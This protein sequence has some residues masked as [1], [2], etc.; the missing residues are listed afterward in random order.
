MD[1]LFSRIFKENI[2]VKERLFYFSL[3]FCSFLS[4]LFAFLCTVFK[5]DYDT[6]IIGYLLTGVFTLFIVFEFFSQKT[7][8]LV[9]IFLIL[10]DFVFFPLFF[11]FSKKNSAEMLIYF[12]IGFL[13]ILIFLR[14]PQRIVYLS[15]LGSIDLFSIIYTFW[16]GPNA[17]SHYLGLGINDY[18]RLIFAVI[19]TSGYGVFILTFRRKYALIELKEHANE[20]LKVEQ[21]NYAKDMFMVNVSHEIRTPLNAIIGTTDYLLDSDVSPDIKEM[22]GSISNSSHA[23]LSIT[24]DLLD[25][26]RVNSELSLEIERYDIVE[27]LEDIIN[28]FNVRLLDSFVNFYVD[29]NPKLPT[30]IYG[31]KD[32]IRQVLVTLLSN[33][34]KNTKE[35]HISLKVDF[36]NINE[37]KIYLTF[38]VEDTGKRLDEEKIN[39]VF[40]PREFSDEDHEYV[41]EDDI[42]IN[43]LYCLKISGLLKGRLVPKERTGDAEGSSFLFEIEQDLDR[44]YRGIYCGTLYN[45]PGRILIYTDDNKDYFII[46]KLFDQMKI[47][48]VAAESDEDFLTLSGLDTYEFIIIGNGRYNEIKDMM[49]DSGIN[50]N[51]VVVIGYANPAYTGEPFK[52]SLLKPI[53]CLNVAALFNKRLNNSVK[54]AFYKGTITIPGASIL[55]IDDNRTNLDVAENLMSRYKA[56]IYKAASGKEGLI[57]LLREKI[58]I[59]FLD[60][61]MPDMD[62]IDTLKEIRKIN[63]ARIASLPVIALTANVVSGARE[64]FMDAGF[65]SFLSKPIEIDKLER[66]LIEYAPVDCLKYD[67]DV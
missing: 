18:I 35:G 24:S 52:Y 11:I 23:L 28:Q 45:E 29:I 2:S 16:L 21:V 57:C 13:F 40:Y 33:A 58:D 34:V 47:S 9:N 49:N 25:F 67:F 62:G 61:M 59:V 8:R 15:I 19:A 43:L 26:S 65:D 32:K 3:L 17:L 4:L 48:Y 56:K 64:M 51:K 38:E 53:T 36:E 12:A 6:I 10:I 14:G 5:M 46:S 66:L 63:D 7:D 44:P 39:R 27:M 54:K 22:V 37:E 55:I 41:P 30:T 20:G 50:W 60:Y 31:D 1:K 42:S